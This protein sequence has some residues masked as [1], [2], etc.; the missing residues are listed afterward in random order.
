MGIFK[1]A[2]SRKWE[3]HKKKSNFYKL[4]Y[5]IKTK[6]PEKYEFPSVIIF[7]FDDG[8]FGLNIAIF[9]VIFDIEDWMYF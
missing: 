8:T 6:F 4:E 2:I 7:P 1:Y 9:Q 3:F 5:L